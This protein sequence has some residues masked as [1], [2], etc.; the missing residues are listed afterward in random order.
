MIAAIQISA[1]PTQY[2]VGW[3]TLALINAGLAQAKLLLSGASAILRTV[4]PGRMTVFPHR[5]L[6]PHQFA[7]MSGAHKTLDRMMRSAGGRMFQVGG[8]WRVPC[9]RSA[10][11]SLPTQWNERVT[12]GLAC[13]A[14]Y[15]E[16]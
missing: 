11:R 6:E 2:A 4:K 14:G 8:H 15:R 7:P 16:V 5:E 1:M 9:H 12:G 3:F 10:L 13:C